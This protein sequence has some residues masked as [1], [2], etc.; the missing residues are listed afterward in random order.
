MTNRQIALYA[1][2][3]TKCTTT[4]RFLG[5]SVPTLKRKAKE[6]KI[7]CY[8]IDG[9]LLFRLSEVEA[10]IRENRQFIGTYIRR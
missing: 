9:I 1:E 5:V 8:A 3:Y 10:A 2:P 4:A 7:P 6:G